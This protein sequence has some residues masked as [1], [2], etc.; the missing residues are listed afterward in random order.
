MYVKIL[1]SLYPNS[2]RGDARDLNLKIKGIDLDGRLILDASI[3]DLK[4]YEFAVKEF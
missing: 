3:T 4:L 1:F 2:W